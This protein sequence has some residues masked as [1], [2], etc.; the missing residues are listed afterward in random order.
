MAQE[1]ISSH[2]MNAISRIQMTRLISQRTDKFSAIIYPCLNTKIFS[3][4][5]DSMIYCTLIV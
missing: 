2:T 5:F 4:A 1:I 3:G